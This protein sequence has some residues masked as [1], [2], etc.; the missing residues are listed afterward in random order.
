MARVKLVSRPADY[1][2]TPDEAT[3]KALGEL[4]THLFPGQADPRIPGNHAAI[5]AVAHNP[6]LALQLTRLTEQLVREVPWTSQRIA[7]RQLAIQTLN[8]HFKCDFSFQAHLR[9]TAAAGISLEQQAALPLWRKANLFNDE[10]RLVIEYTLAV[11]SGDVPAALFARVVEQYGE[12]EAV[13]FTTGI[14]WWSLWAMIIN[15]TGTDFDF[16]YGPAGA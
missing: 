1:P 4:F 16:G 6:R 12:K 11:V 3:S 10:Q 5:A 15:A 13:E 14:A 7:A 2:G 9:P 8:L